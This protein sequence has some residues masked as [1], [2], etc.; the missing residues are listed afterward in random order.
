MYVVFSFY[1]FCRPLTLFRNA[2]KMPFKKRQKN[3]EL[4]KKNLPRLADICQIY[5][6]FNLFFLQHPLEGRGATAGNNRQ[7]EKN[8]RPPPAHF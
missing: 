2:Q 3:K 1:F 4:E 8:D 5:V 6:A 7:A